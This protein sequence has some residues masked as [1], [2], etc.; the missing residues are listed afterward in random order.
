LGIAD[1]GHLDAERMRELLSRLPDGVAELYM[2]P[3]TRRWSGVDNLPPSYRPEAELAALLD[4]SVRATVL[5]SGAILS[6]FG[7]LAGSS[8]S[9]SRGAAV[10]HYADVPV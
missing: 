7:E 4:P 9:I 2:H 3:A 10:G 1:T 5:A 6:T 8:A